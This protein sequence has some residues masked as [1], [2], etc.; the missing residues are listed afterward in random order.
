MVCTIS[1]SE[2]AESLCSHVPFEGHRFHWRPPCNRG[3]PQQARRMGFNS[4][5]KVADFGSSVETTGG[6]GLCV[7]TRDTLVPEFH[8]GVSN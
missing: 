7:C 5:K 6:P 1:S 2:L 4:F 3:S 8:S